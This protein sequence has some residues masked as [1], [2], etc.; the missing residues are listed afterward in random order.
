MGFDDAEPVLERFGGGRRCYAAFV[1]GVL[2]SYGW[3]SMEEE[4]VSELG[5]HIR[6][7]PGNAYIWDCATLP[8]YRGRGLYPALLVYILG[9]LQ[10][11][12][13]RR[14][15]IGADTGSVASQKGIVRA[16]FQPIAD[17]FPSPA[18]SATRFYVEG[19]PGA[20]EELVRA[21]HDAFLAEP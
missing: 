10:E 4:W 6:L 14:V 5:L 19:R 18:R 2:V 21:A 11:K 1:E 8:E 9:D 16:G 15:W 7:A 3:V 12:G 17:F 13:V 20:P